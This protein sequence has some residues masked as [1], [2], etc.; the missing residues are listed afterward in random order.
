MMGVGAVK[1]DIKLMILTG[2]IGLIAGACSMAIGEFVSVYSQLD[3][4]VVLL[5]LCAKFHYVYI[6]AQKKKIIYVQ[7]SIRSYTLTSS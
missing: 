2:F 1:A 4:E 7:M 3:I 6:V 5:F